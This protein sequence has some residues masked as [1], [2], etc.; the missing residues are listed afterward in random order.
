MINQ[1]NA[2][3]KLIQPLYQAELGVSHESMTVLERNRGSSVLR[4]IQDLRG[5]MLIIGQ[6]LAWRLGSQAEPSLLVQTACSFLPAHGHEILSA[7]LETRF[8]LPAQPAEKCRLNDIYPRKVESDNLPVGKTVWVATTGT[9]FKL[10]EE[11]PAGEAAFR[12]DR[13]ELVPKIVA[14]G[15]G[16][17]RGIWDFI[18]FEDRPVE[19]C[20]VGYLILELSALA[21]KLKISFAVSAIVETPLG[22]LPFTVQKKLTDGSECS[23]DLRALPGASR[24]PVP[25]EPEPVPPDPKVVKILFLAANPTDTTRLRLGKEIQAIDE[26]L[27]QAEFRDKFDIRQHWA[28]RV[29]DLQYLL[30]RHKPNIV[31]FS[32]HGSKSSE[33]ILEDEYGNS[34]SVSTRA[35]SQL[36]SVL[37]DNIQCVVLNA[38]YSEQQAQAIANHIDCVVG[39][40]RAIR[41]EA[42]ISF[43]R[44]FYQALGFGKDVKTA[45]ELGRSQIDLENLDGQ[46]T[47][48][49]LAQAN[50]PKDIVFVHND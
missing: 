3:R 32:G 6:P 17:S 30:L 33:I 20:R 48:K 2:P 5:D 40:S 28:V 26:A 29:D 22:I 44:A 9:G 36:F 24:V 15:Q 39:M 27:R 41:D 31:H 16:T 11:R 18:S 50:N 34:H 1:I 42:A 12:I 46:D 10:F 7:R 21:L 19:G 25:T 37:K 49:L 23:L 4:Q 38:C 35:L 14:A 45:F 43:A 13:L 47:P 8:E